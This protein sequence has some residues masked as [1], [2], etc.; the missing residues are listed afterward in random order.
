MDV[1]HHR[2]IVRIHINDI[3]RTIN[4]MNANQ[5]K[6]YVIEPTLH[7][8]GMYSE[9]AVNLLLGTAAQ[10]SAMGEYIHQ[11]GGPALGIYQI[12]MP[13][14]N[15]WLKRYIPL[16]K[17]IGDRFTAG[18]MMLGDRKLRFKLIKN[19]AIHDKLI[20]DL[21]FQTALCR[22]GY[23]MRPEPLPRADDVEGLARYW[24]KYHNTAMGRGT[25]LEFKANYMH[26]VQG[27]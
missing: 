27:V 4:V 18:I 7:R 2:S 26:Y 8:M 3:K 15:D 19:I 20:G 1:G 17:A 22:I 25:E 10:E 12:E 21:V 9:A 23:Y 13:T 5:L 24:K 14:A 16:H 11:V 6:Q